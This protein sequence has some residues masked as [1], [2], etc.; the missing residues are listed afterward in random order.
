MS[1][2]FSFWHHQRKSDKKCSAF[3]SRLWTCLHIAPKS[4]ECWH[5]V[6]FIKTEHNTSREIRWKKSVDC[7]PHVWN[8]HF[9][10]EFRL[11]STLSINVWDFTI[12]N[13]YQREIANERN[14][15]APVCL[16]IQQQT[17]SNELNGNS[18]WMNSKDL[19]IK[20]A[21]PDATIKCVPLLL[22]LFSYDSSWF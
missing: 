15:L 5:F 7:H 19:S 16:Q 11:S 12:P 17:S 2:Q 14:W 21:N 13:W 4:I 8:Q 20:S 18:C 9:V 22:Y 10:D 6:L 1:A 3:I